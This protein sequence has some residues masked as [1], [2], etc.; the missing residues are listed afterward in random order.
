MRKTQQWGSSVVK[1]VIAEASRMNCQLVERAFRPKRKHVTVVG[2]AVRGDDILALLKEKQPDIAI[3]SAQLQEGALEGYRVLRE[4]RSFQTRTRAIM[5]L[6]SR[7]R[8]LVI[9]AFRCGARGVVFRD[10]PFETLIKCIHAVH[11]G[12]V[13]A[14]SEN[15][16]SL[17]EALGQAM[18][19]RFRDARG[20]ERLSK[21]EAEVVRLVAEGLTNKDISLQLGLSEHTVRNYL[22]HVF[23]KIGVSTRVELVLYCLQDNQNGSAEAPRQK[24]VSNLTR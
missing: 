22:F 15:M 17:L 21:R 13:W 19:I 10:E 8:E 9:D 12:Q 1:V 14:D 20:I 23:D 4:M 11:H 7:D 2:S 18:P 6:S 5:L 16:R 24:S 3:I